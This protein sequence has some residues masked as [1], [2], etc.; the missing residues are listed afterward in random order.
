MN[1]DYRLSKVEI[2]FHQKKFKEAEKA[3]SDLLSEDS[4]NIHYLS[5]LAEI[6]LQQDKNDE[7]NSIIRIHFNGLIDVIFG[8]AQ[9][10][11]LNCNE[12]FDIE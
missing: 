4:N 7:A 1:E 11:L 12:R 9:P 2:L 5:L 3:L 8:I 10:F 6:Y